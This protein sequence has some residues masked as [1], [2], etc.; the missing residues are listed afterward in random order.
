MKIDGACHCGHITYQAEVDPEKVVVCH[1]TDC[2][3]ASGGGPNYVVLA[4]KTAFGVEEI[5]EQLKSESLLA[6]REV[7]SARDRRCLDW[8]G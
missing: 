8:Y 6:P 3:K 4:P 5:A 2:Q 7:D 1:C